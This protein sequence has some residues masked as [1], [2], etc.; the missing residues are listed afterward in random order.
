[1]LGSCHLAFEN[2]FEGGPQGEAFRCRGGVHR[3][4]TSSFRGGFGGV[5][6]GCTD[7]G[8]SAP[9]KLRAWPG[10]HFHPQPPHVLPRGGGQGGLSEGG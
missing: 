5:K 4:L 6:N 2:R 10:P 8:P 9:F 3:L 7:G 1:V